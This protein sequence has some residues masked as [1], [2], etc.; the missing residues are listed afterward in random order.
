MSI[1]LE[2]K[3]VEKMQKGPLKDT[4]HNIP[5]TCPSRD[6]APLVLYFFTPGTGV[7]APLVNL[8]DNACQKSSFSWENYLTSISVM[9]LAPLLSA[10]VDCKFFLLLLITTSL[11]CAC[12]YSSHCLTSLSFFFL[13]SPSLPLHSSIWAPSGHL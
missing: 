13:S 3:Q 6:C 7:S 8:S 5:P 4:H 12:L 10:N 1:I 11:P 2:I 9:A